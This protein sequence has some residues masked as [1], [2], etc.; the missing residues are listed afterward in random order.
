MV[1]DAQRLPRRPSPPRVR[2]SLPSRTWSGLGACGAR[3]QVPGGVPGRRTPARRSQAAGTAHRGRG[4]RDGGPRRPGSSAAGASSCWRGRLCRCHLLREALLACAG[5]CSCLRPWPLSGQ[6]LHLS[7]ADGGPPRQVP[8]VPLAARPGSV[9]LPRRWRVD[10][11]LVGGGC[12]CSDHSADQRGPP[13][14]PPRWCSEGRWLCSCPLRP[15][16]LRGGA[17]L[18]PLL[19][20]RAWQ[21]S[22][23]VLA[24]PL[25]P[26]AGGGDKGPHPGGCGSDVARRCRPRTRAEWTRAGPARGT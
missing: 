12:P 10:R 21:G 4:W 11:S 2:G 26:E 13:R 1:H 14:S 24:L 22:P 16:I 3:T 18:L 17:R 23:W 7:R 19:C 9:R 15:L 8:L 25:A 5:P 6:G 20:P